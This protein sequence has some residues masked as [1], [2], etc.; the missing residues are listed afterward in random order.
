MTLNRAVKLAPYL[1]ILPFFIFYG[2]FS[3]FPVVYSFLISLTEWNG[4]AEMKFIAFDNYRRLFTEDI[5]F[6]RSLLNT[7]LIMLLSTTPIQILALLLALLLNYR[8]VLFGRSVVRNLFFLPYVMTPV[9]VGLMFSLF[10]DKE[11]GLLNSILRNISVIKANVDWLNIGPLSRYLTAS[12]VVWKYLGY[13]TLIY[14]SGLQSVP[15]ELY[16]AA[17]ID[18]AKPV[19]IFLRIIMPQI[20]PVLVF[21]VTMGI[22]GGLKLFEEPL[23]LFKGFEGGID[24]SSQTMAVRFIQTVFQHGLYGY[25]AAQGYAMFLV[26]LI[27]SF[28]YYFVISR[29]EK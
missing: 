14:L 12:V 1:F 19:R 2:V 23:M 3:A 22:I 27:L 17:Q 21:S 9:A 24:R 28:S 7:L 13:V 4:F 16:E 6:Y 10:F 25:G 5:G 11:I 15:H 18:G 29:R 26:I 8:F 20:R